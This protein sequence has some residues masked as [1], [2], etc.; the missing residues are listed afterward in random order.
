MKR[1]LVMT[2]GVGF[3]LL[4]AFI[5]WL[6][7]L[8]IPG[9]TITGWGWITT[10][11]A[12]AIVITL[13][14]LILNI[15][16][17]DFYARSIHV[18]FKRKFEKLDV[19]NK[20]GFVF[21]EIDGLSE[22][23]LKEALDKG[24]MPTLA[25]LFKNGSYKIKGWETDLSSQTS[26]SQA[27]ILHGCNKDIPAFRW[28][29]K[30]QNNKIISSN[31][32]DDAPIIQKRISNGKG[33]LA[34]NGGAIANLFTGDSKD[35]IFVYSVIKN[36]RQLYSESWSAFYST[37]FNFA[38]VVALF[39]LE[40]FYEMRSRYRQWRQNINP[41]LNNRGLSYYI[42]RAGANTLLRE[43]STYTVIGDIIA[44]QKDAVYTTYMG[45]DE[46]AHHCGVRDEECFFVLNK[47]DERIK[48]I[49]AAKEYG[50][51]PY[52]L[53]ILSDHGQ[54]NGATFKQRYGL[55]LD[56]L[57]KEL[58]P[59]EEIIYH[60]LNSNKDH[61]DQMVT[62]PPKN[63]KRRLTGDSEKKKQK[64]ASAIVLASG[65]LGLIYFTKWPKRL[66]LEEINKAY[67]KMISGLIS[68]EG[69][70]FIMLKSKE[71]GPVV[72]GAKGRYNLI[73]DEVEGENPLLNYGKHAASHIRRTDSFNYV[74]DILVMSM[75][76][77]EKNETAAFEE[78]IGSHGGLG[79]EQSEPFIMYPSEWNLDNENIIGAEKLY[80]LFKAKIDT[81]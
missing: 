24:A 51:R 16:D 38:Q 72:L 32:A 39:I 55:S 67:P 70:G 45:Y 18:R 5:M 59:K 22:K 75:Y 40:I 7:T 79:G 69:V 27:G 42:A 57:V 12:V 63:A 19:K 15:D 2:F 53:C 4:S 6:A 8:L 37:P 73:N 58:M 13:I 62:A 48:R 14:T 60:E 23:V 81:A 47:I 64:S 50:K 49:L 31:G 61:F 36:I 77:P 21:L 54:T 29:D 65:N 30:S 33:L 20:P 28:V 52:Y 26:S 66:T 34:I 74:P 43:V 3:L 1:F 35:N 44:G 68:H 56:K 76:D 41:R 71:F 80:K 78:L 11:V 25:E 17:Y 10:P 9:V 46:V